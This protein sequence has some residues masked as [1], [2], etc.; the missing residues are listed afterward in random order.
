MTTTNK[1]KP[2]TA[3]KKLT[4]VLA[5]TCFCLFFIHYAKFASV[6]D[7]LLAN[8]SQT[9]YNNKQWYF[10]IRRHEF[11]QLFSQAWWTLIHLLGYVAFPALLIKYY[12]KEPLKNY[13]TAWQKTHHYWIHY[14]CLALPIV[15]FAYFAS[16]RED[17]THTYP[18]YSLASRSYFD[19]L[20]W[21][22]LYGLQ[23]IALEFFFRG[24]LLHS[25]QPSLKFN[26][27][28]LMSI[29]YL[30]IHF[31]K[32]WLEAFGALPFGLLLGWLALRSRSI[33]GGA[34]VHIT[35]AFSMDAFSLI[36]GGNFPTQ[37]WP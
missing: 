37:W 25:L 23:F 33:W 27:V 35:I 12:F 24:F 1:P 5:A 3:D 29:P 15:I 26:A 9:L 20:A 22:I 11:Y 14:C 4:I 32:P 2:V 34:M 8:I 30:M 18:F 16:Y 17:F 6:F 19:L 13:G 10:L 36:R 28:W 7:Q 21:Q 31:Q